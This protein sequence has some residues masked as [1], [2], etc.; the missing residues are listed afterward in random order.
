MIFTA[1]S[2]FYISL[3][4]SPVEVEPWSILPLQTLFNDPYHGYLCAPDAMVSCLY[5]S[6]FVPTLH[7]VKCER[8]RLLPLDREDSDKSLQGGLQLH[9]EE[10]VH[11]NHKIWKVVPFW[12][13]R[14]Q[15]IPLIFLPGNMEKFI[16]RSLQVGGGISVHDMN[17]VNT[18]LPL[19]K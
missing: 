4:L 1:L 18:V 15:V 3:W 7:L 8:V 16:Q 9:T 19:L 6:D 5:Y 2:S 11:R 13:S 10:A 12:D 14:L 17:V